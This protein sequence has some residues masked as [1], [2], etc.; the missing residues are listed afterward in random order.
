MAG[1]AQRSSEWP[2]VLSLLV[3]ATGLV[4]LTFYDWR[5]GVLIF[6]G[7]VVLAGLLRATLSDSAAGLLHVR[8]RMF[9]TAFLLAV[10]AAIVAL[11]LIVP[12]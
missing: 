1:E 5:N 10:G 4:I 3:A 7:S 2:L 9:D 11:G 6:A 12:N 8:G